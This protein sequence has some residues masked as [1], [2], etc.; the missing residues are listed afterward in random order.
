MAFYKDGTAIR[1]FMQAR[2]STEVLRKLIC[3]GRKWVIAYSSP[4]L[5]KNQ[6]NF[7]NTRIPYPASAFTSKQ[8]TREQTPYQP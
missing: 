7:A 1:Y 6:K 8:K 5:V 3:A 2:S 4:N